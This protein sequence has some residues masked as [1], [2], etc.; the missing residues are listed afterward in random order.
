[1]FL[2][3]VAIG[4]NAYFMPRPSTDTD[5]FDQKPDDPITQVIIDSSPALVTMA[6][7]PHCDGQALEQVTPYTC[8]LPDEDGETVVT[9]PKE[10]QHEGQ[11]YVFVTWDGCSEG[12][13]DK[14]ICK[15]KFEKNKSYNLKA[16]YEPAVAA[17]PKAAPKP[18]ASV[19]CTK[20]TAEK[21]ASTDVWAC[22]FQVSKVPQ[23]IVYDDIFLGKQP[24]GFLGVRTELTCQPA[25]ACDQTSQGFG[26]ATVKKPATVKFTAPQEILTKYCGIGGHICVSNEKYTF[27]RYALSLPANASYTVNAEYEYVCDVQNQNPAPWGY[28]GGTECE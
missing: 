2:L 28:A 8:T 24:T 23:H 9:A 13:I 25:D 17:A 5:S 15:L 12:N 1:M 4:V 19:P 21:R 6:G 16:T 20:P 14:S 26:Q 7:S 22:S 11:K 27:K 10:I 3:V 18:A